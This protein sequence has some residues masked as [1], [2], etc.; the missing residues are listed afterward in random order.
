MLL[1]R[2][3]RRARR[4]GQ[5]EDRRFVIALFQRQ[6]SQQEVRFCVSGRR[7][8]ENL[9]LVFRVIKTIDGIIRLGQ[10]ALRD[11]IVGVVIENFFQDRYR[12]SLSLSRQQNSFCLVN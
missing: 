3:R 4:P 11:N 8:E 7:F 12:F 10:G 1:G 9:R 2:R 5:V 6:G